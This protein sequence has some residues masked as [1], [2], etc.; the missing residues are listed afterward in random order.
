[1]WSLRP[2]ATKA[3]LEQRW[4]ELGAKEAKTAFWP[5]A[6]SDDPKAAA[7]L[8][9]KI[10]PVKSVP[11]EQLKQWIG[12]LNSKNFKVRTAATQALA[13]AGDLARPA[14]EL[15]LQK[16][17]TAEVRQRLANLLAALQKPPTMEEVRAERAIRR[18]SWRT[19]TGDALCWPSR[20]AARLEHA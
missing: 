19:T 5:S 1:M 12:E 14:L 16:P 13:A 9:A 18:W 8:R 15:A 20:R 6:L 3:T 11:P 4:A 17:P 2:T 10:V 7:F